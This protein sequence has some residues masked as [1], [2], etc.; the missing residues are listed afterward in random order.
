MSNV[1]MV[2]RILEAPGNG[3]ESTFL[4]QANGGRP[5]E[6]SPD[7]RHRLVTDARS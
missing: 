5:L 4:G 3:A 7:R 6:G 1:A 2:R